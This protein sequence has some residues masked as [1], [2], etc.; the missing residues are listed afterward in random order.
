MGEQNRSREIGALRR[1][2]AEVLSKAARVRAESTEEVRASAQQLHRGRTFLG[3]STAENLRRQPALHTQDGSQAGVAE[4]EW[5]GLR[6]DMAREAV[7]TQ[8]MEGRG[9]HWEEDF[10]CDSAWK[11]EPTRCAEQRSGTACVRFQRM[12]TA[13]V[14][15]M[16]HRRSATKRETYERALQ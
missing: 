11:W 10:S 14:L 7:G 1:G 5:G 3:V 12:K 16:D 9:E 8:M 6:G 13:S 15:R 2:Q 4:A